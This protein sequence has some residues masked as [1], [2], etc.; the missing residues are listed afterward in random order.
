MTKKMTITL[1]ESLIDEIDSMALESGKKKTQI[2]REALQ[3]YFDMSAVTKTVTE[4]KMGTLKTV[5][6]SDVRKSLGL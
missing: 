6:H 1:E 3:D 5:K 4:H 2:I